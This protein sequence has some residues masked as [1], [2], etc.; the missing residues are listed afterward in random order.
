VAEVLMPKLDGYSLFEKVKLYEGRPKFI[1]CYSVISELL[2][3]QCEQEDI[4]Q[5]LSFPVPDRVL[6]KQMKAALAYYEGEQRAVSYRRQ[7]QETF[8]CVRETAVGERNLSAI[9][10][11]ELDLLGTDTGYTGYP[12]LHRAICIL[13]NSP[14]PKQMPMTLLYQ[15]V[16]E[17]YDVPYANVERC[18][19]TVIQHIW[20]EGNLNNIKKIWG[21]EAFY[22]ES[23]PTNGAFIRR[24]CQ[25]I[26]RE[27]QW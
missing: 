3:A 14:E 11:M 9:V 2:S 5:C 25:T 13:L 21:S 18:I 26:S 22:S 24:L 20:C 8:A 27:Y 1:F 10:S 16:A 12:Y 19:R 15:Q 7:M 6:K 4:L 23:K 17:E